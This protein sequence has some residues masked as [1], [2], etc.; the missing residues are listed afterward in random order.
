MGRL[1]KADTMDAR[2]LAQFTAAVQPALRS[3]SD[4]KI[5]E[6]VDLL[7]RRGAAGSEEDGSASGGGAVQQG[8]RATA[9]QAEGGGGRGEV[10]QVLCVATATAV[11]CNPVIRAFYLQLAEAGKTAKVALGACL[12]KLLVILNAMVHRGRPWTPALAPPCPPQLLPRTH[13]PCSTVGSPGR[14]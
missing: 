9:G 8:Q 1:A 5:R 10:R 2:V 13:Y 6:L 11:R 7:A 4:E 12:R 14:G 3:L